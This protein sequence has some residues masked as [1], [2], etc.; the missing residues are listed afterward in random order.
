MADCIASSW[1]N[2]YVYRFIIIVLVISFEFRP[3]NA[4]M[5]LAGQI[6]KRIPPPGKY[7]KYSVTADRKSLTI[8][9]LKPVLDEGCYIAVVDLGDAPPLKHF[10]LEVK[11]LPRKC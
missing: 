4:H 10:R 5:Q 1:T 9:K 8:T 11:P 7:K 2:R 3:L 6:Y